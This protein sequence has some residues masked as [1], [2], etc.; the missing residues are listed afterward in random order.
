MV[1]CGEI[2]LVNLDPTVGSE[3]QKSRHCVIISLPEIHNQLRIIIAAM[4]TD[5]KP[6]TLYTLQ[7]VFA[8]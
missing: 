1:K 2:W 7:E 4:S 8:A 6:T 3:I 5:N